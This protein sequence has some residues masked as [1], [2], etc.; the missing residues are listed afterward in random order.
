MPKSCI[1]IDGEALPGLKGR[2]GGE[3]AEGSADFQVYEVDYTK[4]MQYER[5]TASK[6]QQVL[7]TRGETGRK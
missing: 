1:L 2:H 3:G 4:G 7:A 6:N 5:P